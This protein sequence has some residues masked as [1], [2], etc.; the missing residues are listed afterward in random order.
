MARKCHVTNKS[1]QELLSSF[2]TL[3]LF[4]C[5]LMVIKHS[6]TVINCIRV[7]PKM[8]Y[9]P[10]LILPNL[11]KSYKVHQHYH[12]RVYMSIP[13]LSLRRSTNQPWPSRPLPPHLGV[14]NTGTAAVGAPAPG[15]P[16]TATSGLAWPD[17]KN[18]CNNRTMGKYGKFVDVCLLLEV[19]HEFYGRSMFFWIQ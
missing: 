11:I 9:L 1:W 8:G 16:C 5:Y 10:S 17:L 4:R 6:R 18:R 14:P 15:G 7:C 19:V 13:S 2:S 3:P 12:L